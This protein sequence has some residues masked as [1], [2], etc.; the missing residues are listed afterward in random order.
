MHGPQLNPPI[1]E[2]WKTRIGGWDRRSL[3]AWLR[4]PRPRYVTGDAREAALRILEAR[5]GAA[6]MVRQ[7]KSHGDATTSAP[8][9]IELADFQ[10]AAVRRALRVL[11]LRRGVVIADSVGLGKT[12]IALALVEGALREGGRVAVV[13]PASLRREWVRALGRLRRLLGVAEAYGVGGQVA[14]ANVAT[15]ATAAT[16]ASGNPARGAGRAPTPPPTAPPRR[17]FLAWVSHERLSRGTYPHSRLA[18]LDLVVV[19]EAHAFRSAR[20]RRYRALATLCAGARVV[21]ITATP[22]NNSVWDLYFQLRLFAGDDAFRDIGVADLRE[23]F[24]SAAEAGGAAP[25]SLLP[26]LREIVIRRTRPFL[27]EWYGAIRT[28]GSASPVSFPRRA[29]PVPIRYSLDDVEPGVDAIVETLEHLTLAA[30]RPELYTPGR[31]AAWD[32]TGGNGVAELV[33]AGLLK[34]LESSLPALRASLRR[35]LRFHDAFLDALDRGRL[36][37]SRDHRALYATGGDGDLTQLVLEEVALVP[38][39]AGLDVERLRADA[40]SD[41]THIAALLDSIGPGDPKLDRLIALL[42]REL[43]GTKVLLFTEYRDTARHLWHALVGRGGVALIDG[44]GAFLG[45]APAG[46]RAVIERFAPH[47]N[48]VRPPHARE[49]VDLLIATDV[50]AE[51][52]NLQDAAHV[53]SYDLP[54]NPVRLI[55]RI[56][57]IDRLGS[58]HGTVHSYHFLPDR[59]LDR[60]LRLLDRLR[61]KLTAIGRTVGAD[62]SVLGGST[63]VAGDEGEGAGYGALVDRLA[64]GAPDALDAIEQADAGVFEAVERLYVAWERA[65]VTRGR[66]GSVEP[67][68]VSSGGPSATSPAAANRSIAPPAACVTLA[69]STHRVLVAHRVA[70]RSVWSVVEVMTGGRLVPVRDPDAAAAEILL[71]ALSDTGPEQTAPTSSLVARALDAVRPLIAERVAALGTAPSLRQASVGAN[72]ARR[73]LTGLAAIPGGPEPALCRRADAILAAL[74]RP[75]DAGTELALRHAIESDRIGDA[76]RPVDRLVDVLES[77]LRK[78]TNAA[79][80]ADNATPAPGDSPPPEVELLGLIEARPGLD[81]PPGDG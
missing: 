52:L 59:G 19:D 5:F 77:V 80:V 8:R 66:A 15:A 70:D 23:A 33:R 53:V 65:G 26:V 71:A 58:P 39:P 78:T 47:A 76:D 3:T 7:G 72:I 6:G 46:R 49:R 81:P 43:R 20:T 56:G 22:V 48:R 24:R 28:P 11:E 10:E 25:P 18:G 1:V 73:L 37:R 27:R 79:P 61:M 31:I 9:V 21:L 45:T 35:Q 32:T 17:A 60:A 64:A 40:A 68:A 55:Q 16:A 38:L 13:T 63:G 2:K 67:A 69:G 62:G 75:L 4:E 51:G 74:S 54:W 57:R 12:Y 29:P 14:A 42:D 36:L 41:R 34:R 44:D 50:L 30:L